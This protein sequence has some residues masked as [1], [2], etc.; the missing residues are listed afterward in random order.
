MGS[1]GKTGFDR[2]FEQRMK[3]RKFANEYAGARA[4]VDTTDTLIRALE[5]ARERSGVTKADLARRINAKP[6]IVRRLLTLTD[7]NPTMETVLKVA[8]ALGYHLELVRSRRSK[9]S[10]RFPRQ[11]SRRAAA[12]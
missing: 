7:G 1:K 6:E 5:A 2:Y 11:E 4:E 8:T 12:G 10:E 9:S 3:D